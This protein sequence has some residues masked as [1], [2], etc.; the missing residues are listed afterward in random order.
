MGLLLARSTSSPIGKAVIHSNKP[1]NGGVLPYSVEKLPE[2][3]LVDGKIL[4]IK[5]SWEPC[6]DGVS[7][8]F[9]GASFLR[10]QP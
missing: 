10:L 6:H 7:R 1:L 8:E 2:M 4:T 5:S 9:S 3:R